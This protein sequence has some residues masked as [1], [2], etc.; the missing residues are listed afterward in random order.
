M[1]SKCHGT[2]VAGTRFCLNHQN[3]VAAAD[4]Q[5]KDADGLRKLYNCKLWRVIVRGSV[6]SRDAQ[7]AQEDSGMRCP[8]LATEVDH[9]VEAVTWVA[10]GHDFYDEDNLRGLCKAHHNRRK[11]EGR[12]C[13]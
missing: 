2:A 5:R 12:H 10:Q 3:A 4:R 6:L 9:I 13:F 1:C 11:A 7:C 8:R